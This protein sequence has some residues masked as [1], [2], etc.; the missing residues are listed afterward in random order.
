MKKFIA[1]AL[2][3]SLAT[4]CATYTDPNTGRQT[5]QPDS[6]LMANMLVGVLAAGAVAAVARKQCTQPRAYSQSCG[7]GGC[8]TTAYY[9]C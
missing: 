4:G 9:G 2:I 3:A 5:Q 1:L 7:P 8:R 6:A